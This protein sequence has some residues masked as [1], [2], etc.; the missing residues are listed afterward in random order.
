MDD[1]IRSFWLPVMPAP[2][3]DVFISA[4]S[5]E[6]VLLLSGSSFSN[7]VSG[8][9]D[10]F[11]STFIDVS[12]SFCWD[13][14]LSCFVSRDLSQ[15][16]LSPVSA[17]ANTADIIINEKRFFLLSITIPSWQ[18]AINCIIYSLLH[19][20]C[21]HYVQGYLSCLNCVSIISTFILGLDSLLVNEWKSWSHS[22][23][24]ADYFEAVHFMPIGECMGMD[25]KIS[26]PPNLM[27]FML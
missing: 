6:P 20:T 19:S 3:E 1:K 25:I 14:A 22:F 13:C 10:S 21:S 12:V 5:P 9:S 2:G 15:E 17:M 7:P 18:Q 8:I 11:S 27:C 23:V 26:L 24:N 16:E 4:A